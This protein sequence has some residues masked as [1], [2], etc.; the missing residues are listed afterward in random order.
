[1]CWVSY[2]AE[3]SLPQLSPIYFP[4]PLFNP[5][6]SEMCVLADPTAGIGEGLERGCAVSNPSAPSATLYCCLH[7]ERECPQGQALRLLVWLLVD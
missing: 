3:Q 6:P 4:P 7:A 2:A 5:S 1:M